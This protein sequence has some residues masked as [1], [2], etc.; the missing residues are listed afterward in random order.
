M[1]KKVTKAMIF[2][3]RQ[4]AGRKEF[5]VL[6]RKRGDV[7]VLTGHREPGESIEQTAKRETEEELGV[8]PVH[9]TKLNYAVEVFLKKWDK[10]STE[11]AF[12]VEIPNL[13]VSF[14]EGEE[15]HTWYPLSDLAEVL[16]HDSQK[17]ALKFIRL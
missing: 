17:G 13:D 4:H 8:T 6:H 15:R 3:W 7:V 1:V 2:V 10:N 9:V 14:Q 5:F 16:T 11:H 12:L